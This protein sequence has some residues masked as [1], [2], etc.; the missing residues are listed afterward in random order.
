MGL[1]PIPFLLCFDLV[2]RSDLLYMDDGQHLWTCIHR[3][4]ADPRTEGDWRPLPRSSIYRFP[5]ANRR[6]VFRRPSI[7]AV[8]S[9]FLLRFLCLDKKRWRRD[10]AKA[11]VKMAR[12]VLPAIMIGKRRLRKTDLFFFM[13]LGNMLGL[14]HNCCNFCGCR[15]FF[16]FRFGG[17]EGLKSRFCG[18]AR[19]FWGERGLPVLVLHC[20]FFLC[21]L[22]LDLHSIPRGGR[23]QTLGIPLGCCAA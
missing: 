23:R 11:P 16:S 12:R 5:V 10:S 8:E 19:I 15:Y 7:L 9:H 2:H 20:F 6:D 22:Y 1:A 14:V 17:Y 3:Q 4:K 13:G 21:V 18:F